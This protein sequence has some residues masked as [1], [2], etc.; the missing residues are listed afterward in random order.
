MTNNR[1]WMATAACLMVTWAA[2]AQAAVPTAGIAEH[3][4]FTKPDGETFFVLSL[5]AQ[6]TTQA[7]RG[8]DIVVFF[9][10]SASQT[11][12]YRDKGLAALEDL[13]ATLPAQDKVCL[14][15]VDV[16]PVEISPPWVAPQSGD[17]KTALAAMKRR[18]PLGA[19]D[20]S[21]AMETAARLFAQLKPSN[22]GRAVL[23]I[24]DGMSAV[25][26]MQPEEVGKRMA[27]LV[28][29]RAP[30]S[31]YSI[32]PRR[33]NELLGPLANHTGGYLVIDYPDKEAKGY[34]RDL[35]VIA[36]G[37]VAWPTAFKLPPQVVEVFPKQFP[38]LRSDR[39]TILI[40]RGKFTEPF[41]VSATVDYFGQKAPLVW[42][43]EPQ[44]PQEDHAP[45][46]DLVTRCRPS[47]G[48]SLPTCGKAALVEVYRVLDKNVSKLLKLAETA[49]ATKNADQA[50]ILANQVLAQDPR[51]LE[52][53]ALLTAVEKLRKG[54]V[55]V[56]D[57]KL[58]LG[59]NTPKKDSPDKTPPKLK[60]TPTK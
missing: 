3:G 11:A 39:E 53:Q 26:I 46:A 7:D 54:V 27:K 47:D 5:Q 24:G 52:A 14:Y 23:Y 28:E 10:T 6:F 25:H 12:I 60:L 15:A 34:A 2:A 35:S 1:Q 13:M 58:K 8:V 48:I 43:V 36:H 19:T 18:T 16:E 21:L 59:P 20:M 42:Q 31:S 56:P 37:E 22:R 32:G 17:M 9:D 45:L 57:T 55:N 49:L 33:D 30:F 50:E 40:G 38:P 44:K 51:N 29:Q 4:A 41:Q